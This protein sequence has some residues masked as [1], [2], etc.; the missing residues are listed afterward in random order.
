M[1]AVHDLVKRLFSEF[2]SINCQVIGCYQEFEIILFLLRLIE[3]GRLLRL[4]EQKINW[5]ASL[6]FRF[7]FV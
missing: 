7:A 2:K 6:M 1:L 5:S 3:F 4:I